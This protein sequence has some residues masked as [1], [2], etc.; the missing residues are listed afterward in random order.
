MIFYV[1]R[2]SCEV[3][4]SEECFCIWRRC[5]LEKDGANL[6]I[7]FSGVYC[8]Y[9]TEE[10]GRIFINKVEISFSEVLLAIKIKGR[11]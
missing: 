5:P 4:I 6:F 8:R 3:C 9:L 7:I 2:L 1:M 10:T 11:C